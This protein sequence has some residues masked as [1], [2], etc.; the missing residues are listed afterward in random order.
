M[1][2]FVLLATIKP[3]NGTEKWEIGAEK[4]AET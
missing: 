1:L 2:L 4:H 3:R